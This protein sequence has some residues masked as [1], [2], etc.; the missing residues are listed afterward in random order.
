MRIEKTLSN[1]IRRCAEA[2]PGTVGVISVG[3]DVWEECRSRA[4]AFLP[5]R[6]TRGADLLY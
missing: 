4:G 3:E 6:L 2:I 1:L 5:F